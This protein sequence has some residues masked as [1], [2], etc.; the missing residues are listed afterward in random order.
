MPSLKLGWVDNYITTNLPLTKQVTS[1][2][3]NK[4][5][6][7]KAYFFNFEDTKRASGSDSR[8]P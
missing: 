1:S 3:R 6:K 5:L 4:Y 7:N 8:S 2:L